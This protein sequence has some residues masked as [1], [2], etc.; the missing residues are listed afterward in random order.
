V[1]PVILQIALRSILAL[2]RA[3]IL[4]PESILSSIKSYFF[5]STKKAILYKCS[6]SCNTIIAY[7]IHFF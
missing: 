5:T 1:T 3:S 6:A 2:R 4:I 7:S